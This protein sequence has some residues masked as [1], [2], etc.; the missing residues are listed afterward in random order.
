M[1]KTLCYHNVSH[2]KDVLSAVERIALAENITNE[3]LFLLKSAA[4]CHDVG[5]LE[6]YEENEEISA[7]FAQQTLPKYG[8]KEKHIKKI[9]E[10]IFVTSIPQTPKTTLEKIICDADLDYLGRDDFEE[11]S[12]RLRD[13][14][15]IVGKIKTNKEWDEIQ[16][17]FLK[18]HKYYTQTAKK[19]RDKKKKE[20]LEK[21]I[22][23]LKEGAV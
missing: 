1:P 12:S 9:K 3:G 4:I 21:I 2:T 6:R 22:N 10:L 17:R 14:L 15:K 8:Y 23:R 19:T 7:R 5:F 11:V 20:N 16:V 18:A 13:E